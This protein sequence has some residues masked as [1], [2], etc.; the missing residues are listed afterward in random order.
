[1]KISKRIAAA[2]F[3]L[4]TTSFGFQVSFDYSGMSGINCELSDVTAMHYDIPVYS[5]SCFTPSDYT[6]SSITI[7]GDS[8]SSIVKCMDG[9]GCAVNIVDD[10]TFKVGVLKT[11]DAI[12]IKQEWGDPVFSASVG[13]VTFTD[14]SGEVYLLR[15]TAGS[16]VYYKA[17][18]SKGRYLQRLLVINGDDTTK[19]ETSSTVNTYPI[20]IKDAETIVNT[21]FDN[22]IYTI[23]YDVNGSE[24]MKNFSTSYSAA[25][26]NATL[27]SKIPIRKK[28][29]F[30]GWNSK[31]DG[32]GTT[33]HPKDQIE[34]LSYVNLEEVSL[35]AQWYEV[36]EPKKVNGC[37]QISNAQELYGFAYIVNGLDGFEQEAPA[38][39]KL[40][41]DITINEN[42]L[43]AKDSV[44]QALEKSFLSWVPMGTSE[45]PFSGSFNG[46]NHSINGIYI[47]D[48]KN[49]VSFINNAG[50]LTIDSLTIANSYFRG[51][52]ASSLISTVHANSE[53]HITNTHSDNFVVGTGTASGMVTEILD[54]ATLSMNDVSN[55]SFIST[56]S[57]AA[58]LLLSTGTESVTRITK[59]VNEG[60][61]LH[62]NSYGSPAAGLL[63]K[64]QK[65]KIIFLDS[66]YNK[67]NI[68]TTH[69]PG[70]NNIIYTNK[71]PSFGGL[72]GDLTID[73]LIIFNSYNEGDLTYDIT[74]KSSDDYRLS[75]VTGGLFA[76]ANGFIKVFNSH[77]SGNIK[78]GKAGGIAG[79]AEGTID[80]QQTYNDG[81]VY[82]LNNYVSGLIE[83]NDA[84]GIVANCYNIGTTTI[85]S[86][87]NKKDEPGYGFFAV[88][89]NSIVIK[90][91]YDASDS[92]LIKEHK[93][94]Y[95]EAGVPTLDNVFYYIYWYPTGQEVQNT[96]DSYKDGQ[97]F[98]KLY[99]YIEKDKDGNVIEGGING[100]VWGQV[101]GKDPY[102]LL[103][104]QGLSYAEAYSSSSEMVISSSESS[105]ASSSSGTEE[106]SSSIDPES[107]S[108]STVDSSSS[109]E[110][111]TEL[112]STSS[113][114]STSV[115]AAS[116]SSNKQSIWP[117]TVPK[118]FDLVIRGHNIQIHS[119]S[120]GAP[121][122]VMDMQGRV[123]HA[124]QA[125]STIV[126]LTLLHA[127]TYIITVGKQSKIVSIN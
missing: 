63:A 61:I 108:E 20:T 38:C 22:I 46:A 92:K 29:I 90:N 95:S 13:E 83:Y 88:T 9:G 41:A 8:K 10:V 77:N 67:G 35:Y 42:V 52:Q 79:Y 17:L 89:E 33:Y 34:H 54:Y 65:A 127:G 43:T 68:T 15:T 100:K 2:A 26:D 110:S 25:R 99:N 113:S 122:A 81:N 21:T 56:D 72:L 78:A 39:G 58:G 118:S 120:L 85:Y 76:R 71:T 69:A 75:G 84:T 123:I 7:E 40:T 112:S 66:C 101:I 116:S 126:N 97:I 115:P 3:F 47:S 94:N 104:G 62:K 64:S 18:P 124:S 111:N 36:K 59:G 60:D 49:K 16:T 14:E 4:A 114:S 24:D 51:K 50:N 45:V 12:Y 80:I 32:S 93:H 119:N 55:K 48:A 6:W 98:E 28:H 44:N 106:S 109:A 70:F 103:N 125:A 107:S 82:G 53:V 74:L 11:E 96:R 23:I 1:M 30:T 31:K 102:P 91:S 117:T 73:S 57:S 5:M 121:I 37:Y 19:V 86:P 27:S 87:F 105:I